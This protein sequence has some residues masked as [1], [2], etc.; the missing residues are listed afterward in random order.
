MKRELAVIFLS[1]AFAAFAGEDIGKY[2]PNL[3]E[4]TAVVTNGMKWIDGRNMP[5]E[6]RAFPDTE[7]VITRSHGPVICFA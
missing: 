1:L 6:G 4:S 5:I 3:A 2:D 7:F